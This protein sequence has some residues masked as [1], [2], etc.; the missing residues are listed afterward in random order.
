MSTKLLKTFG[1][2]SIFTLSTSVSFAQVG[3]ILSTSVTNVTSNSA[4]LNTEV[5]PSGY[6]STTWFEYGTDNNLYTSNETEHLLIDDVNYAVPFARNISGLRP[7]T[8]YYFR[9]VVDNGRNETKGNIF[10][11]V[12]PQASQS[13]VSINTVNTAK[14]NNSNTTSTTTNNVDVKNSDTNESGSL[15]SA[16]ALFG[17]DFL[18][19]S[20]LG[21]LILL[22]ILFAIFWVVRKIVG[23]T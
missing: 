10:Y 6:T 21:W 4:T 22:L 9:T 14:T 19:S 12:T 11:F 8:P 1:I 7:N 16:N 13:N 23:A 17:G 3:V 20:F 15:L 5:N 2:L 18:P